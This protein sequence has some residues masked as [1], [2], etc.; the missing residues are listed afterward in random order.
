MPA[1]NALIKKGTVVEEVNG[2]SKRGDPLRILSAAIQRGEG[3]KK[4]ERPTALASLLKDRTSVA[5]SR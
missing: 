5:D 4:E 1:A 2:H 3:E